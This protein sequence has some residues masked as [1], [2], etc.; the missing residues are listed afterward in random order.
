MKT[1]EP[2]EKA[3]GWDANKLSFWMYF[4]NFQFS[5]PSRDSKNSG[6]TTSAS[7]K[8]GKQTKNFLS[9]YFIVQNCDK[10]SQ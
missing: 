2:T 8:D 6:S 5:I 1:E 7:G 10:L 3:E 9:S 4:H